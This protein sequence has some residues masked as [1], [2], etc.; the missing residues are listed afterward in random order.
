MLLRSLASSLCLQ[1]SCATHSKTAAI[2]L[3]CCLPSHA[4][5]A[6]A[7]ASYKELGRLV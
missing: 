2:G 6:Q 7:M 4:L 3:Y 1:C 5:S